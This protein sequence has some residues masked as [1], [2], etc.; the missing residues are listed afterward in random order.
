MATKKAAKVA[1]PRAKKDAT[2]YVVSGRTKLFFYNPVAAF[3][4]YIKAQD[5]VASKDEGEYN[6][7]ITKV[8]LG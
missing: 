3:Q 5:W 2:I 4:T 7:K 1:K 6:Y 8:Q